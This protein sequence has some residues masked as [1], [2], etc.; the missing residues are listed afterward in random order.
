MSSTP[1]NESSPSPAPV[2]DV[3][4]L[5]R[6][7]RQQQQTI[8]KLEGQLK[9]Q[10]ERIEQLETELRTRKKLK[11]KPK[12]SPSQLN[13]GFKPEPSDGKRA[14]S[15]KRSKKENFEVDEEQI[16]EPSAIPDG[17]E[18]NG[19]RA[20]DVQ[21]IEI[22]RRNI[23]FH[24]AEYVNLDGTTVVGEFMSNCKNGELI[25]RRGK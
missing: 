20:Y 10:Q 18:F 11:G 17:A 23:R 1:K 21:E 14:G 15:T 22:R 19:Y 7:V 6:L 4:S 2:N 5:Q 12:I 13:K 24:L 16:V 25:F 8:E 9:T 3:E